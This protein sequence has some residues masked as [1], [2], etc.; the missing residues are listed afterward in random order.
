MDNLCN[1]SGCTREVKVKRD[2]LCSAHY[3]VDCDCLAHRPGGG[4]HYVSPDGLC[5]VE[6]CGRAHCARGLCSAH[7]IKRARYGES[8][9]AP[10][11]RSSVPCAVP[12]CDRP[13]RAAGVLQQ[14]LSALAVQRRSDAD[15]RPMYAV[16]P[17]AARWRS[18]TVRYPLAQFRSMASGAGARALS[19]VW[20]W[21]E[22]LGRPLL[23]G[24]NVHHR[25]GDRFDNRPEN[26]ELWVKTQP[27][28]QRASIVVPGH[29]RSLSGTR[30]W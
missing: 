14:A 25:N 10:P 16:R 6:G 5:T 17:M 26:L 30:G 20:S 11:L 21:S 29:E 2:Q 12:D 1:V 3:V 15:R 4:E 24:E 18:V 27:C 8:M 7:Y 23:P 28:G 19:T 9:T 22:I 13:Y